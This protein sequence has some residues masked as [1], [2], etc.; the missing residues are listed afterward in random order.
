VSCLRP[1]YFWA[2]KPAGLTT[3][4]SLNAKDRRPWTDVDDGFMEWL[5]VRAG[6]TLFPIHRLDR[7]TTGVI[8]FALDRESAEKA[9]AS[10]EGRE[11]D[12]EYLFVTDRVFDVDS[13]EAASFI[14]RDGNSFVSHRDR[15]P[16]AHTR[17]EKVSAVVKFTLWRAR[18]LTGK[19]HQIR[20]HA[21]DIGI[22][23]L[24]DTRHGGSDFPTLCLHA[25]KITLD[26]ETHESPPPIYFTGLKLLND[27]RLVRWLA[28]CDRRE[29][30]A[31]S[32]SNLQRYRDRDRINVPPCERL[33]HTEGDPLRVE[34]LGDVTSLNWFRDTYP[35]ESEW[36]SIAKLLELKNW[37]TWYLQIRADR[38]KDPHTDRTLESNPPPPERWTAEENGLTYEFRRETGLSPGLFLDQRQNRK[39]I[40]ETCAGERVL[41]LFCYTGG[42]SVAAAKGG[43]LQTVSVDVSK[44]FLDW[45]RRNFELNQ[46]DLS[47]HEFRAIDSGEFL[48]WAAKKQ[49]KF[50]TVICDP[51][52]FARTNTRGKSS[53]FRIETEF[54]D[55]LKACAQVASKRILFSINY[56]QWSHDEFAERA[57]KALPGKKVTRAPSPDLDFELPRQTRNMK[58]IVIEL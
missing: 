24:G 9:R 44:T 57:Q 47:A 51:P 29:R 27:P 15:E 6:V 8:A 46:V 19:P 2:D 43:A 1:S 40:H 7:E 41:N 50:E 55:L 48:A 4:T 10:F 13:A 52:S 28:A 26:G 16:N 49:L 5:S 31:R 53:V 23:L 14:E 45:A 38:G 54:A 36:T 56:E 17:F 39:W 32:T 20:L 11:V 35:T 42:F 3:H 12:K 30:A 22:P 18:P 58:A 25:C 33:I 37:K 34:Q 21:E